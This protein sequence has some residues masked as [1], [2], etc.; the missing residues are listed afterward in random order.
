M[1]ISFSTA[2]SYLSHSKTLYIDSHRHISR[3]TFLQ[4]IKRINPLYANKQDIAIAK[5]FVE[6][7]EES[8]ELSKKEY[9]SLV[10]CSLLFKDKVL[11]RKIF[12]TKKIKQALKSLDFEIQLHT[13][14]KSLNISKSLLR[15]HPEFIDFAYKNHFH[16]RIDKHYQKN[17]L[18]VRF[19]HEKN[20]FE[21]ALRKGADQ[22][23]VSWQKFPQSKGRIVGL[24]LL[25]YGWEK[26][27]NKTWE[28]LKPFKILTLND[29]QKRFSSLGIKN[30]DT[31]QIELVTTMPT[32]G[33]P[34]GQY[35]HLYVNFY[36]PTPTGKIKFYSVGYDLTNISFPD[37]LEFI[38][39]KRVTSLHPIS[40]NNWR[41]MKAFIEK[42]QEIHRNKSENSKYQSQDKE[43]MSFYKKHMRK[44]CGNFAVALFEKVTGINN[45]YTRFPLMR[46]LFPKPFHQV[47]DWLEERLP[48]IFRYAIQK[49]NIVV[50]GVIPWHV[51]PKQRKLAKLRSFHAQHP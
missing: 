33:K 26:H 41:E 4:R 17:N 43:A 27:D 14:A 29:F 37:V 31:P 36:V 7:L 16:H 49:I 25:A 18:G 12:K 6:F 40:H 5:L 32:F 51:I 48:S 2:Q 44:N 35:G 10:S 24:D 34:P 50:R 39:R 19:N 3:A 42:I 11:K 9:Y 8:K 21:L 45:L 23:W 15:S 1:P 28:K 38:R 47:S 46:V 13:L 22:E 30:C 20:T